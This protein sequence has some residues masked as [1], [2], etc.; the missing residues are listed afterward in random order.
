MFLG[1]GG[2]E[3]WGGGRRRR[4]K[5]SPVSV[6]EGA[7]QEPCICCWFMCIFSGCRNM[8]SSLQPEPWPCCAGASSSIWV[9]IY[10]FFKDRE[11]Y[12]F[13]LVSSML[14][15]Y[16]MQT[17]S[18][19][20]CITDPLCSTLWSMQSAL[21]VLSPSFHSLPISRL[22]LRKGYFLN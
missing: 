3:R 7:A 16:L 4:S 5:P 6:W 11:I 17:Q 21:C 20:F 22:C 1:L 9:F 13:S 19:H 8:C 14:T 12:L 10:L 2:R 15:L 18:S